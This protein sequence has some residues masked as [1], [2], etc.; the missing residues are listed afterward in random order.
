MSLTT[1]KGTAAVTP[2]VAEL[3]AAFWRMDSDE[4]AEFFVALADAMA[5]TG[6]LAAQTQAAWIADSLCKHPDGKRGR[7]VLAALPDAPPVQP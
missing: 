2:S 1:F 7:E 3:A 4:Q 5:E 6:G